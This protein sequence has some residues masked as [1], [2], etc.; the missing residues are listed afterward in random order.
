MYQLTTKL[1][2]N[3]EK[4]IILQMEQRVWGLHL[5]DYW[6]VQLIQWILNRGLFQLQ[7]IILQLF[8]FGNGHG[9]LELFK[10]HVSHKENDAFREGKHQLQPKT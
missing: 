1:K 9:S 10:E 8:V 3:V 6:P 2:S 5:R 4:T 7:G